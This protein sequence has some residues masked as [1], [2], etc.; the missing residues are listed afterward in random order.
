MDTTLNDRMGE[1]LEGPPAAAEPARRLVAGFPLPVL[2]MLVVL[3]ALLLWSAWAT[4]ELLELRQRRVVSVSL[5]TLVADFVSAESRRGATPEVARAKTQLYLTAVSA[6]MN[7]LAADGTTVLVS[8]A[9][10]GNSVPNYTPVVAAAVDRVMAA[11]S[12]GTMSTPA[13]PAGLSSRALA[14]SADGR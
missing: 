9:V 6:A 5:S 4:R 1:A 13:P 12:G 14:G 10:V 2:A 3:G 11:A 8:E 7:K